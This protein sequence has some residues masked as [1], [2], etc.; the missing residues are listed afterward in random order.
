MV[1]TAD[2]SESGYLPSIYSSDLKPNF[3]SKFWEIK[4]TEDKLRK[5]YSLP[6][7]DDRR[8]DL[9]N[10]VYGLIELTDELVA[11]LQK[12]MET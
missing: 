4:H 5:L 12:K 2:V 8:P 6:K 3:N 1:N 7:D 11:T 10:P 9:D